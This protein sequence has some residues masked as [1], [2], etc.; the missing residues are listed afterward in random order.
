MASARS[1]DR[2][3]CYRTLQVTRDAEPEVIEKAYRA[4]SLKYHPDTSRLPE[5]RATRRMQELNDAYAVL[6]D[7]ARRARYD[8]T[9]PR[10]RERRSGWDVFLDEGLIGLY[11]S[12][13]R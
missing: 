10:E 9:L 3:D 5:A 1:T 12:G 2:H 13:R 8:A 11:L 7:P 6:S 4:L